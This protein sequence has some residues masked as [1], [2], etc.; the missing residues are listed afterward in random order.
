MLAEIGA[1]SVLPPSLCGFGTAVACF[2]RSR[3]A[4]SRESKLTA[5][6]IVLSDHSVAFTCEGFE[7]LA[8]YNPYC[9][10]AGILN[11]FLALYLDPA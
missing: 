3:C 4:T 5:L 6:P 2:T 1:G 8:V 11:D 7:F 10:P 9:T